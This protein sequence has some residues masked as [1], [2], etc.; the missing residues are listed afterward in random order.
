MKMSDDEVLKVANEILNGLG[1]NII[2][3]FDRLSISHDIDINS[4]NF[5][6]NAFLHWTNFLRKRIE[7]H[8]RR[9]VMS[10]ELKSKML[11][12]D[13]AS[14]AKLVNSFI[15][16]MENGEDINGHL[17]K[18]IFKADKYDYILNHWNIH[19]LHLSEI[20]AHNEKEMSKNRSSWLLFF[21]INDDTA[22]FL[23][24]KK[25]PR[26]SGFTTI[27]F[28]KIADN[29]N[30]LEMCGA[31]LCEGL[32]P[33][34]IEPKIQSDDDIFMCYKN[35]INIIL[36]INQRVYSFLGTSCSGNVIDDSLL[37]NSLFYNLTDTIK[38]IMTP[39]IQIKYVSYNLYEGSIVIAYQNE[40]EGRANN[41]LVSI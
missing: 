32:T 11:N 39:N 22:Y 10:T 25:H 15:S 33:D 9:V 38:C 17:S 20:E 7:P 40:E 23:D 2:N 6:N 36:E 3:E 13:F 21:I 41:K 30:W 27:E 34:A 16:K 35:N 31:Q 5:A 1:K 12:T 19:H 28:L 18:G 29:N 8:S 24:I 14:E 26:G 37:W 4:P